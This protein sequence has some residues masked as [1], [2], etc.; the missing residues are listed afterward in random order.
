MLTTHSHDTDW[1][2]TIPDP[3]RTDIQEDFFNM[4]PDDLMAMR[5]FFI[6]NDEAL[7][8][9]LMVAMIDKGIIISD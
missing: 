8:T 3:T 4:S 1:D 9:D 7:P 2:H 5:D 6:Q